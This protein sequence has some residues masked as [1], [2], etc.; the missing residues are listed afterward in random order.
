MCGHR[1][2]YN[3]G[4]NASDK[5]EGSEPRLEKRSASPPPRSWLRRSM[6]KMI[7]VLWQPAIAR[8]PCRPFCKLLMSKPSGSRSFPE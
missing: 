1:S 2:R 8:L 7:P 3:F 4:Q 6:Q 5:D